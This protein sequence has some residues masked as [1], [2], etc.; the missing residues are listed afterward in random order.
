MRVGEFG[1]E[2]NRALGGD[3]SRR[4]ELIQLSDL[5]ILI[6]DGGEGT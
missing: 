3:N 5:A 1:C 6:R 4:V 2:G